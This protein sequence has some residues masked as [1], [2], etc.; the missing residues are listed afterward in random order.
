MSAR[1]IWGFL[2]IHHHVES[3]GVDETTHYLTDTA[4]NRTRRS[5]HRIWALY[6][7]IHVRSLRLYSKRL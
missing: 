1:V 4:S 3:V 2:G 7:E 5:Y 6:A